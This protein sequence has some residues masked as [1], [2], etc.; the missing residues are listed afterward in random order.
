MAIPFLTV[1]Q[2]IERALLLIKSNEKFL[3]AP[4]FDSSNKPIPINKLRN[5]DGF[6]SNQ[7]GLT[8]SIYP[9]SYQG[10]SNETVNSHNAALVYED[11]EIGTGKSVARERC[12]LSLVVSLQTLGYAQASTTESTTQGSIVFERSEK[13]RALYRWATILWDILLT[14]PITNLGGLV[15]SSK[16]NWGAFHSTAWSQK[17]NAVLHKATLLWN[18]DLYTVR[19]FKQ[20]LRIDEVPDV[21]PVSSWTFVGVRRK[22]E[23]PIYWDDFQKTLVTVLGIPLTVTP[24]GQRVVWNLTLNR[25]EDP[26]TGNPLTPIEL[27]DNTF[28]PLGTWIDTNLLIV[29]VMMPS[30]RNLYW[31]KTLLVLQL[32]NGT[33]ITEL[34]DGTPI[35]YDPVLGVLINGNT[36]Q[37]LDQR[38]TDSFLSIKTG[39]IN[40]YEANTLILRD[41]F[42]F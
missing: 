40:I 36:G 7:K 9:Y 2:V 42:L 8:L 10:T 12:R 6:D 34:E 13:E 39:R 20:F 31:N 41:Q 23:T 11:F 37:P 3:N 33:L 35:T 25:F 32:A 1:D 24:K 16:V 22:D 26:S 5:F 30:R 17:D 27:E 28:S 15:H 14:N 29:G 38:S 18:L 21:G 19:N 4:V